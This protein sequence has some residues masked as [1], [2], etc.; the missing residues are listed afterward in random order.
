[1]STFSQLTLCGLLAISLSP[2][3]ASTVQETLETST[4]TPWRFSFF[5]LSSLEQDQVEEGGAQLSSYSFFTTGY[6]LTSTTKLALRIPFQ[7][8][9]NGFNRFNQDAVQEQE[10]FLHDIIISY[11]DYALT[12]LPGNIGVYWEGRVYIP[13]SR[14]SRKENRIAR[15]RNDFILNKPLSRR[16]MI[17]YI[18]K[19]NYYHQSR[20]A[21]RNQFEDQNGFTIE[22]ISLTKRFFLDH[23]LTLW[24]N[25][26][27]SFALGLKAGAEDTWYNK[28]DLEDQSKE[29]NSIHQAK[30]GPTLRFEL[31][32]KI[33]FIF[34][35]DDAVDVRENYNELG[36][37]KKTNL[38]YA[39]LSFVRF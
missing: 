10:T 5:N 31:N 24:F 4:Y 36:Q 28:T 17:E 20:T 7:Y 14:Q 39:L 6:K 9:S 25:V 32:N 29:K 13:T 23:W 27:P 37:F 30:I 3:W 11:Q 8:N 18:Q 34:S 26:K 16:W 38:S 1:M 33:N 22:T 19:F 12:L 15:F 2:L 35:V 21:Y